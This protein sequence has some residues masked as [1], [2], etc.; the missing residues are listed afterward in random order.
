MN[1]VT[2]ELAPVGLQQ[3]RVERVQ[4]GPA[5]DREALREQIRRSVDQAVREGQ[6]SAE[7][8]ARAAREGARAAVEGA[9]AAQEGALAAAQVAPVPDVPPIPSS[10]TTT[11]TGE[12]VRVIMPPEAADMF[13][14]FLF[15]IAAVL[16][17][18][19]IMSAFGRR[20]ERRAAAP[21]ALPAE[22]AQQIARIEQ[23]VEAM[24][25]EVERISE[26][27]RFTAKLL[28]ERER[29]RLPS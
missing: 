4:Q 29:E 1:V 13:Y 21:V 28:S 26:G 12:S 11:S 8:G 19:P 6:L 2:V 10:G 7:E 22:T 18:R 16:I 24:A 15:T 3:V 25:I 27:Q 20:L 14:A 5:I 17:L 9:R 23:A